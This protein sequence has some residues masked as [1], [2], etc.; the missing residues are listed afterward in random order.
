MCAF[1]CLLTCMVFVCCWL[2]CNDV[3]SRCDGIATQMMLMLRADEIENS[4]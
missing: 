2:L 1:E 3:L 4:M